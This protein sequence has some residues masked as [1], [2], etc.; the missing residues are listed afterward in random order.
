[1]EWLWIWVSVFA[2]VVIILDLAD[3]IGHRG[4]N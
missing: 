2:M 3:R 1:M 4:G